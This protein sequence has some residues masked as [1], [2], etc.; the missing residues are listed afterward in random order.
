MVLVDSSVWIAHFRSAQ[1]ELAD[2]LAGGLVFMHPFVCGELACGNLKD[3]VALLSDLSALPQAHRASDTEVMH[4]IDFGEKA[5]DGSMRICWRRRWSPAAV[6]GLS[7]RNWKV[8]RS[9]WR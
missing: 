8:R 2:L 9:I 5:S 4:L 1:A 6:S 3:R 7:T